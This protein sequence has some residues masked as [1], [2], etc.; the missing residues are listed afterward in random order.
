VEGTPRPFAGLDHSVEKE[1][2]EMKSLEEIL[3]RLREEKLFLAETYNVSTL[4]VFGSVSRGEAEETSDVDI[5]VEF[6]Q[7][8]GLDFVTL[9]E[10][11][12]EV[13]GEKVDLVSR[14]AIKSRYWN[15]I[16]PEVY[17]A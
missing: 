14:D 13:L 10:H 3:T 11:L 17:Y 16:E 2:I 6:S 9:A 1:I 8:I 5:V 4:G 7:P 12:E 15:V